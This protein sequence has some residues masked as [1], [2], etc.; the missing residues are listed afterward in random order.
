LDAE[1]AEVAV[2]NGTN[3]SKSEIRIA[4]ILESDAMY[5]FRFLEGRFMNAC[6]NARQVVGQ[7]L[8]RIFPCPCT[9]TL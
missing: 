1:Q 8:P 9:L 6:A 5:V 7:R 2:M 3:V 4:A